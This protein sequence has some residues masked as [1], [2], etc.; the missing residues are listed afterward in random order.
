V[1]PTTTTV[2]P[3]TTTTTTTTL[4]P[5]TL[6]LTSYQA[7]MNGL[8]VEYTTGSTFNKYEY[9]SRYG[10][11]LSWS[12]SNLVVNGQQIVGGGSEYNRTIN[13]GSTVYRDDGNG[14]GVANCVDMLNVI[15][16]DFELTT[17]FE[18]YSESLIHANYY[19]ADNFSLTITESYSLVDTMDP[20][21]P[22]VYSILADGSGIK[23]GI[24]AVPNEYWE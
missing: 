10:G 5:T 1:A 9:M 15:M 12:I 21:N 2:A 17:R 16:D 20:L 3:T 13:A 14:V 7:W 4:A 6:Q 18:T 22:S 23:D 24:S 19:T 8:N 11:S